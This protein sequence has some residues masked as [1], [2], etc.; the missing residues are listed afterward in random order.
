M[1]GADILEKNAD[2]LEADNGS[3]AWGWCQK[4]IRHMRKRANKIRK[5]FNL[6]EREREIMDIK[7]KRLKQ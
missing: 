4:V 1:T 3:D 2:L 5:N 6:K 7:Q